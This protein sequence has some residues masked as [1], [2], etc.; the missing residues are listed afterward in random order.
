LTG[1]LFIG[2]FFCNSINQFGIGDIFTNQVVT[3][4]PYRFRSNMLEL[5]GF[6][7]VLLKLFADLIEG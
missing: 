5:V 4:F 3:K 6:G 7:V 1:V 2:E